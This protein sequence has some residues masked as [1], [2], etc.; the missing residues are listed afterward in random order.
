MELMRTL[1]ALGSMLVVAGSLPG[2][3]E[4]TAPNGGVEIIVSPDTIRTNTSLSPSGIQLSFRVRNLNPFEIAVSPCAPD[5][6]N[7]TAPDVWEV[8]R[9]LVECIPEPL[10]AGTHRFL[11]AFVGPLAPGRY[12]LNSWYS[13]PD[14]RGISLTDKPTLSKNS[15][16]FVVLP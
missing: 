14:W 1:R 6:E 5:V 4:V 8:V 2:C 9:P 3:A 16:V 10:P 7:E 11:V 12:R 15:N 13:V